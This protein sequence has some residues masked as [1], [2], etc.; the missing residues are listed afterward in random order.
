MFLY[1]V[2]KPNEALIIS[3]FRAHAGPEGDA[4]GLG[5][6]IVV[7]KG[8]FYVPGLQKVRHLSLDIHEAELDLEC[9][10]TQ[11]IRVGVKAVVIYKIA[12]DF[13]SIAN[14]ARRFLDQEEQMDVKVH[15]VFA[16]HLRSI[17]GTMTVEDLIRNRDA[18]TKATR[19][20]SSSEMQRLG[21]TI[22]SLQIQEI[23]DNSGYIDNLS[24]PEAARVAM[25]ARIAQAAADREATQR[26]Q[27]ADALKVAAQSE[28]QMKQAAARANAQKAQA[29][30]EQAGP[31]AA[32]TARQQVVVQETKVAELEAKRIEQKLQAEVRKP[33]DAEA[34]KTRTISEA[35]RDAR[36]SQ[37]EAQAREVELQAGADAKRVKLEAEAASTRTEQIGRAEASA[38]H[39]KGLAEGEAVR[40]K[41]LAEAEA[42]KARADA[43]ASNQEAVIGQQIAEQLPAI[44]GEAAKAFGNIDQLMVLNG[45]E[46]MGQMFTQVL[47]M[48]AAAIPLLRS[49]IEQGGATNGKG[50]ANG[51]AH[52]E[53]E[54]PAAKKA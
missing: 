42:I 18:L 16:G 30:S 4:A 12:D 36:I 14:A 20:S 23:E 31:L 33:A 38:I 5:F 43:L 49:V 3:G 47:G 34:Y 21:L 39:A 44:V 22:D 41:G 17:V 25:E 13:Q 6:K 1:K 15:N 32:A 50:S 53:K 9:V 10:T 2:A 45:A 46:G 35:T 40:A 19:E 37:A 8:A 28:S 26:E 51:T 29:E 7:G 27:E 54:T 48:G 11:G 52:T 24:M